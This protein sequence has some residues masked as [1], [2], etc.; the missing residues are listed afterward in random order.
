[1]TTC[2]RTRH[3]RFLPQRLNVGRPAEDHEEIDRALTVHLVGDVDAVGGPRI[4][5][6][7]D[8]GASLPPPLGASNPT[9]GNAA[10]GIAAVLGAPI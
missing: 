7:R 5:G 4:A 10:T 9:G 8:H 6:L 2:S 3:R 1:M